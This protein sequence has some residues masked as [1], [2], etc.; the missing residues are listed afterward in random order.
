[1]IEV[2]RCRIKKVVYSIVIEI[3]KK[4]LKTTLNTA[5]RYSKTRTKP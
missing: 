1:M 3:I 4:T 5:E 2:C